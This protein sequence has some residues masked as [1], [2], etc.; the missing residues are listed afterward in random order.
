MQPLLSNNLF[1]SLIGFGTFT[2]AAL[3]CLSKDKR[4]NQR[5]Y[6][7]LSIVTAIA[8]GIFALKT[9]NDAYFLLSTNSNP[10]K[11]EVIPNPTNPLANVSSPTNPLTLTNSSC[12][13]NLVTNSSSYPRTNS[14]PIDSLADSNPINSNPI[15]SNHTILNSTHSH[16]HSNLHNDIQEYPICERFL[17]GALSQIQECQASKQLWDE[18]QNKG[19]FKIKCTSAEEAPFGAEVNIDTREIRLAVLPGEENSTVLKRD[20]LIFELIN[21]KQEKEHTELYSKRCQTLPDTYAQ[22]VE[23]VEFNTSLLTFDILE[24]CYLEKGIKIIIPQQNLEEQLKIEKQTG[25]TDAIIKRWYASCSPNQQR[26]L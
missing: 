7:L 9:I 19:A 11:P 21:L 12:P 4:E 22:Q 5:K 13:S 1:I 14:N 6:K 20:E 2:E 25:H 17:K 18:I 3:L 15:N 10:N 23:T 24:K 16:S 26:L 8:A